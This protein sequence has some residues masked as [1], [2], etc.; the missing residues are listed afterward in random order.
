MALVTDNVEFDVLE[1][2]NVVETLRVSRVI[3]KATYDIL[4]LAFMHGA[5]VAGGF[6]RLVASLMKSSKFD[7]NDDSIY[8]LVS[9]LS[10]DAHQRQGADID[11]FFPDEVALSEF[12]K[13]YDVGAN[14]IKSCCTRTM[15]FS[16]AARELIVNNRCRVQVIDRYVGEIKQQLSNFDIYNAMVAFNDHHMIIPKYWNDL[17]K[18]KVLHVS[19]WESPFIIGRI[20]KWFR[21]HGYNK[22]SPKSITEIGDVTLELLKQLKVK[23]NLNCPYPVTY[24]RVCRQLKKF[25]PQMTNEKLLMLMPLYSVDGYNEH[26]GPLTELRHRAKI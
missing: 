3:D 16:A 14:G 7:V 5:Y 22:L 25:I 12:W 11:L 15:S 9:Y 21:R 4:Q 19:S 8:T 20:S 24:D 26:H 2:I 17:E 10:Y 18:E 1:D 6:A 13:I 23:P